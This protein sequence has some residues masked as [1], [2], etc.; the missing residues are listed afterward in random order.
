MVSSLSAT[1]MA[2]MSEEMAVRAVLPYL[3]EVLSKV[4]GNLDAEHPPVLPGFEDQHL[5]A[6]ALARTLLGYRDACAAGLLSVW[7]A[8]AEMLGPV[9]VGLHRERC[10]ANRT[11]QLHERNGCGR[12]VQCARLILVLFARLCDHWVDGDIG[13]AVETP[14]TAPFA[15]ESD[16]IDALEAAL[17]VSL[18]PPWLSREPI[19]VSDRL[20]IVHI[21]SPIT[22]VSRG[23]YNATQ[24][25][26][27]QLRRELESHGYLVETPSDYVTPANRQHV[28]A[29]EMLTLTALHRS[30]LLIVF[31]DGGGFGTA[32]TWTLAAELG[33][34]ALV[35]H[36]PGTDVRAA[37]FDGKLFRRTV[38]EFNSPDQALRAVG[39][40]VAA[41]AAIARRRTWRLAGYRDLDVTS[42]SHSLLA[43]DPIA[44]DGSAVTW[45]AALMYTNDPVNWF[46]ARPE[47]VHEILRVL[48]I[49]DKADR[50]RVE[51]AHSTAP[52]P[53]SHV[54][55]IDDLG[56][57]LTLAEEHGWGPRTI[58]DALDVLRREVE[59]TG[60]SKRPITTM[61]YDAWV[62]TLKLKGWDV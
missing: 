19:P 21:A 24:H 43:I 38:H 61:T 22:R 1:W 31:A 12:E 33:I 56:G 8:A 40:F 5:D 23:Q 25:L 30:S 36:G 51:P 52:P 16:I 29:D 28:P 10:L 13:D 49:A 45:E 11:P 57:L 35:L 54:P 18:H 4:Y 32:M 59:V 9:C 27:Q 26:T 37:R 17:R 62:A 39:D 20:P 34:P 46:Q 53:V 15:T 44:F 50:V 41:N 2:A 14:L 58:G 42:L 47:I 6:A 3:R 60:L 7:R 55:S 48:G